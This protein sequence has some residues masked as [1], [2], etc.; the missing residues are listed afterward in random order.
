[1]G[2]PRPYSIWTIVAPLAVLGVAAVAVL[3]VLGALREPPPRPEPAVTA[4]TVAL[5][6]AV[7][8]TYRIRKGDTL[9]GIAERYGV[10]TDWILSLNPQLDPM[11]LAVGQ[12]IN[13]RQPAAP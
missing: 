11:A 4:P 3:L 1:M 12:R 7:P 9:S 5:D 10:T 6:P 13:L 8:A 2:Q